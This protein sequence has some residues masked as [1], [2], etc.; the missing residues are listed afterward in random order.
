MAT[1]VFWEKEKRPSCCKAPENRRVWQLIPSDRCR[2]FRTNN[3]THTPSH[4]KITHNPLLSCEE[5]T[6]GNR[7]IITL[8][9]HQ[10]RLLW[11]H[12]PDTSPEYIPHPVR[13]ATTTLTKRSTIN[14]NTEQKITM[15]QPDTVHQSRSGTPP[16]PPWIS[17]TDPSESSWSSPHSAHSQNRKEASICPWPVRSIS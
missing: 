17:G 10:G 1:L 6:A 12:H 3:K 7:Q 5:K 15:F 4:P 16:R 14:T 2:P 9:T 11:I 8:L 13:P